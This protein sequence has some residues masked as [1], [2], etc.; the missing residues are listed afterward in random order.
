MDT[1]EIWVLATGIRAELAN[2]KLILDDIQKRLTTAIESLETPKGTNII[3]EK[4]LPD[5]GC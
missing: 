3:K 4:Q 1:K 5:G 2:V